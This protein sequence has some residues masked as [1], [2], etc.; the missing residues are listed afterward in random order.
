VTTVKV[1]SPQEKEM[2]LNTIF[3]KSFVESFVICIDISL[4][5]F[6]LT[7]TN[8]FLVLNGAIV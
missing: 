1:L 8:A 4:H 2:I 7:Y 3:K 5:F 6:L